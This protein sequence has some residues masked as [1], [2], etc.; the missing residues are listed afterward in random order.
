MTTQDLRNILSIY[1]KV[2]VKEWNDPEDRIQYSAN[3]CIH[4]WVAVNG[5][6]IIV[7]KQ[8]YEHFF[9]PNPVI[10]TKEEAVD[11]CCREVLRVILCYGLDALETQLRSIEREAQGKA[12]YQNNFTVSTEAAKE[13]MYG[14]QIGREK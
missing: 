10:M 8:V 7:E 13:R 6:R 3:S 5:R 2:E 4:I 9:A 1:P 14:D 11:K 12:I